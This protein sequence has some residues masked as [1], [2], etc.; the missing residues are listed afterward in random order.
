MAG[1]RRRNRGGSRMT[2]LRRSLFSGRERAPCI[3]CRAPLTFGEATVDHVVPFSAGG[4][5]AAANLV[6]AC[7]PCNTERGDMDFADFYR[8]KRPGDAPPLSKIRRAVEA[9]ARR[10]RE[11]V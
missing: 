4:A 9:T 3:Y 6:I 8:L 1:R 10:N 2:A 5:N 11:V 7:G